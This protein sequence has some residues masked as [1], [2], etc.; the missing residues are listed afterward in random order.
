MSIIKKPR[1]YASMASSP[2]DPLRFRRGSGSPGDGDGSGE[3]RPQTRSFTQLAVVFV[4]VAAGEDE[5]IACQQWGRDGLLCS[6]LDEDGSGERDNALYR[7]EVRLLGSRWGALSEAER[8]VAAALSGRVTAHIKDT[9]LVE[10]AGVPMVNSTWSVHRKIDWGNGWWRTRAAQLWV[11]MGAADMNRRLHLEGEGT[12]AEALEALRRRP[13]LGGLVF[14]ERLH[15]VRCRFASTVAAAGRGLSLWRSLVLVFSGVAGGTAASLGWTL[16]GVEVW[17]QVGFAVLL[18]A[19]VWKVGSYLVGH[20]RRSRLVIW[21]IGFLI[22]EVCCLLMRMMST[23]LGA[24][25]GFGPAVVVLCG[26]PVLVGCIY[27]LRQSWVSRNVAALL[28]IAVL[29]LP[30]VLP[31]MGRLAQGVYLTV[32]LGVPMS[33]VN[34]DPLGMY[35]AGVMP[36]GLCIAAAACGLAI[37]GWARHFYWVP[38]AKTYCLVLTGMFTT[39]L[40]GVAL[41]LGLSSATEAASRAATQAKAGHVPASFFGINTRL[42]CVNPLDKAEVAVQPGPLPTGHPVL[43]FDASG[44]ETWLWDPQRGK[45]TTDLAERALRVRTDQIAT[46]PAGRGARSC[47]PR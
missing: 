33:A 20:D 7:V 29:P 25:S 12:R 11:R 17:W 47:P 3:V 35:L 13:D 27:A 42:V 32:C 45:G 15:D 36:A 43:A 14:N 1:R 4:H 9:M 8:R 30:W 18:P 22:A 26:I 40:I 21:L 44:D 23:V 2:V 6:R 34:A 38:A 31:W 37:L 19:A 46:R 24:A 10:P 5:N 16:T 28:P 41:L 39:L